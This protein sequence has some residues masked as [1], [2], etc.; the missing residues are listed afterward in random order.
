[1]MYILGLMFLRGQIKGTASAVLIIQHGTSK[2]SAVFL[3]DWCCYYAYQ[4]YSNNFFEREI[5]T[6]LSGNGNVV[7]CFPT[8]TLK[9]KFRVVINVHV[10]TATPKA[11]RQRS[12]RGLEA[13]IQP[14]ATP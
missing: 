12:G 1:M 10:V 2:A 14:S 6:F 5:Q 9:I 3:S 4:S 13:A 11:G 8:R 7:L